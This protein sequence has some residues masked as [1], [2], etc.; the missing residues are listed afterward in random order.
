MP[1]YQW[2]LNNTNL[3]G[4][5]NAQ[6]VLANV[7]TNQSGA[8]SVCATNLAGGASASFTLTVTP[9]PNLVI[10]E[11]MSS[12]AKGS[13]TTS[14]WWEL[15]NLGIFPVNL[16][17]YRFDDNHDS[18]SDADTITNAVTIAPGESIVLVED[19]TPANFLAWW[20]AQNLP[21]HLQIITYPS[22]G[23]SSSGDAINLWNAAANSITDT[24]ASVTFSTAT[25]GV[26]FGFDPVIQ[27]F[28]GLS[29]VGQ[30]GAFLAAANGDIGSPG[31]ILNLPRFTGFNFNAASGAFNLSFVTQ[32]N[33]N[34][35]VE[36]KNDLAAPAWTVLTNFTAA[37]SVFN[38]TDPAAAPMSPAFTVSS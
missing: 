24:V 5:T 36:Y 32:P 30:N 33:L 4:Q 26:S 19:L 21:P 6:L 28:G 29:V 16:Q 9:K 27:V 22:I 20:G 23:F 14:D 17:G 34:Y 8:Y 1:T 7:Q 38:L 12:E 15:S 13:F 25:R 11:A 37:S 2:E 10:T 3:I 18:F 31:T 35:G